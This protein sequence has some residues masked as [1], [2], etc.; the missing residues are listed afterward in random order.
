LIIQLLLLF[1]GRDFN[2]PKFQ[3]LMLSPDEQSVF[4]PFDVFDDNIAELQES[5]NIF[6]AVPE[7]RALYSLASPA[8][9]NIA[10]RDNEST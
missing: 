8:S 4:V 9:A 1:I 2:I 10:I 5:F 7:E 6:L 3:T